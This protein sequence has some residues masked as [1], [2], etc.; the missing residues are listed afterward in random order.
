MQP[1][2]EKLRQCVNREP[3]ITI[4]LDQYL[5]RDIVGKRYKLYCS[6]DVNALPPS[7]M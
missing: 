3:L 6:K 5:A 4:C 7:V 2:Q 1:L